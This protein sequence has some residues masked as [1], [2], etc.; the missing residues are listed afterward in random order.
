MSTF[1]NTYTVRRERRE[2]AQIKEMQV[3][4]AIRQE[5]VMMGP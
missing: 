1:N 2:E 3:F 5:G 4:G